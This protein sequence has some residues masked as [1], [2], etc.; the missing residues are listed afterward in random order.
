MAVYN[1]YVYYGDIAGILQCVDLNTLTPVWAV[2]TGDSIES[3]PALDVEDGSVVA[4]YTANAIVNGGKNGVCTIRRLNALT[5]A[6]EWSYEVPDLVYASKR[7]IGIYASPVVGQEAIRDL[8]IFTATNDEA[9]AKV[10]AL[11]KA[12]GKVVWETALESATLSSPVAVY[13]EDGD[14]WLI[15]AESNG[16]IHLMDATD[17]S[18]LDTL[19]LTSG[20]G[21]ESTL[22]IEGSPAVYGNLMII[23]TTG[24]DAGGVYCIKIE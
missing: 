12:D 2:D 14:A 7:D 18:I 13:N 16:K 22:T 6:E 23:G 20:E 17:G 5:G 9:G 11:N 15:Q 1:N 24:K 21:E 4:L 3:T 8:V 19:T 10:I